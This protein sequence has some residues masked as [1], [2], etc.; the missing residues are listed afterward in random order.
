VAAAEE[1]A[2]GVF[3]R[4]MRSVEERNEV[5]WKREPRGSEGE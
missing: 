3:S 5:S 2:T 1:D 4:W